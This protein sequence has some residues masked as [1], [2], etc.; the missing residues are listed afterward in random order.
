MVISASSR[1][2]GVATDP[3]NREKDDYYPTPPYA[4]AALLRCEKFTGPIWEPAC[5]DGAISE[6][7]K[8]H[9][10]IVQSTDLVE[11]GYGI[12]RID[13]LM[14]YR[15]QAPNILTNPPF[16]NATDFAWKALELAT[17]K[18]ALL[19]R[20]QFLEGV[21]RRALF[22]AH[23]PKKVLVFSQRLTMWRN[24]IETSDSGGTNCFAW[25]IWD[26]AHKG[27]T[28]LGWI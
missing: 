17:E 5:G 19:C 13:F 25:Y 7:L 24:G 12:P 4:V 28:E 23:P 26:K 8:D 27:P 14:E 10:Y 1:A 15:T 21:G 18:V 22:E 2:T 11:R 20:I 6:V 3:E 9:G 16:K